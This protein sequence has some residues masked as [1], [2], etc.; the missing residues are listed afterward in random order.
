MER[1]LKLIIEDIVFGPLMIL[2]L[3]SSSIIMLYR[4]RYYFKLSFKILLVS[5]V[6]LFLGS[7]TFFFQAIYL[8]LKYLTPKTEKQKADAIVVALAGLNYKE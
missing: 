2:L 7:N 8:P 5:W 1:P 4:H 6:I 3:L